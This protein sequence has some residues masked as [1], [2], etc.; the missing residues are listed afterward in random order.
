MSGWILFNRP[1]TTNEVSVVDQAL[2]QLD[3]KPVN[4]VFTGDS[5]SA[6]NYSGIFNNGWPVQYMAQVQD[7]VAYYHGFPG[8]SSPNITNVFTQTNSLWMR[9]PQGNVTDARLFA[10]IGVND[11]VGGPNAVTTYNNI[12][13]HF[14]VARQFGFRRLTAFTQY[15]PSPSQNVNSGY[16]NAT[17][18][19]Y[20]AALNSAL[21]LAPNIYDQLIRTELLFTT[22]DLVSG[23]TFSADGLHPNDTGMRIIAAEVRQPNQGWR[24]DVNGTDTA[25]INRNG[26]GMFTGVI[27][28]SNLPPSIPPFR[29][30]ASIWV[31]NGYP[32]MLVSTNGGIGS[33]TWTGTNKLG[34]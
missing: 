32:W 13:N 16:T 12:S 6:G 1:L 30:A 33:T 21:T 17:A 8:V 14:R 31:S 5:L 23:G 18:V 4:Y 29:G 34:W 20:Y 24:V 7:G 19:A 15:T 2:R 11:T 10:W 26:L 9:R 22:N 28:L 27:V 3:E 25:T